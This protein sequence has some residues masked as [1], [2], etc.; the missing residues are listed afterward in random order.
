VGCGLV[1]RR[2]AVVWAVRTVRGHKRRVCGGRAAVPRLP[3][4]L[5]RLI[6]VSTQM[7]EKTISGAGPEGSSGRLGQDGNGSGFVESHGAVAGPTL[8]PTIDSSLGQRIRVC[9]GLPALV[10]R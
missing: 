7:L 1:E 3:L 6:R 10:R 2:L 8:G 9:Y 4:S 5:Q